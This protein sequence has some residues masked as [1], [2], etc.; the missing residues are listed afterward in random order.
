[1]HDRISID[2]RVCHGQ[3]RIRGTRITM[4]QIVRMS[5]DGDTIESPLDDDPNL[6]REDVPAPPDY[7]TSLAEEE[8][9]PIGP[10]GSS[11]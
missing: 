6:T 9:P 7:A 11:A 5:A 10:A 4:H 2:P 1:M 8:V 3:A